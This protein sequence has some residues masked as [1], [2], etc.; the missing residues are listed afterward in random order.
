MQ[1][2]ED[3]TANQISFDFVLEKR[4][5]GKSRIA[6]NV[7]TIGRI[8]ITISTNK[9]NELKVITHIHGYYFGIDGLRPAGNSLD[10]FI[11]V[12]VIQT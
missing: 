8:T 7:G 12:L 6:Q 5:F 11:F 4:R 10:H 3:T 1:G 9:F 2:S